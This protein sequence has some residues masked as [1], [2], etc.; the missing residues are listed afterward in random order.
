MPN[1]IKLYRKRYIPNE[2]IHLKDDVLL[3]HKDNLLI[4]KW[5]TLKPRKDIDHGISAYFIN[6][7]LK[8]S[9]IY[10]GNNNIV[11]WY[12]DI[13]HTYSDQSK[14]SIVF[15]DLLV[16]VVVYKDG[17][18]NILDLDEL[19]TALNENLIT[20]SMAAEA[21][22]KLDFLLRLIYSNNFH[23]LTDPIEQIELSLKE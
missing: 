10:D 15:E 16:D 6:D 21:L 8:V 4:T 14:N 9:K 11:Y 13:I 12:C 20:A 3:V 17:T 23:T 7:G 18:M 1:Q 22:Q 5:N 19:G 2:I